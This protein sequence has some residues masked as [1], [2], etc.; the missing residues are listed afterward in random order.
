M[1]K[2]KIALGKKLSLN[3]AAISTLTMQQQAV[4]GGG[5]FTVMPRCIET[6]VQTCITYMPGQDQC[7]ICPEA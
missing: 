7:Y 5:P 4:V 3:K 2:K 6:V 1:R